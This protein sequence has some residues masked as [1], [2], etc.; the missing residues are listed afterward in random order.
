MTNMI[1]ISEPPSNL[2][3]KFFYYRR[4]YSFTH[5]VCSYVGRYSQL[6]WKLVAPIVTRSH[7]SNWEA[8]AEHRILN[9]GG[10]SNTLDGC[11]TVDITPRADAYVDITKPLPF[12]DN[13][14]D[15]IFCEE[16]IEH[17]ELQLG[18]Q[19]LKE[20][21]RILKPG[22]VIRLT[23]PD[24]NWFASGVSQS[25]ITCDEINEI[26]YNHGHRYLYTQEALSLNCQEV[27]FTNLKISK[28]QDSDSQLGYLD[29]HADRF[30]HPP[31]MSQY[32]E[33]QKS[34]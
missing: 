1:N 31:E 5:T 2:F 17:V 8:T 26:F 18:S 15:A 16:V 12:A 21:W 23:T 25:T 11:L 20:C 9:L 27:G 4:K 19:L 13:S 29:S 10:G 22:G 30:S 32:L 6:F 14:I 28:Y 33:A 3:G 7:I 24:L 34:N